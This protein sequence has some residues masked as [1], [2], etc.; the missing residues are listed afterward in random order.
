MDELILYEV[1]ERVATITLNRPEKLNAITPAL[2]RALLTALERAAE[3]ST[4]HVA[5][6]CGAGR[7]FS[8]GYDVTSGDMVAVGVPADR[9]QLEA[10]VRG[11]LA[12]WDLPLPVIA[13]VHGVCLAGGT[14]LAAICDITFVADDARIGTPQLPLGAGYVA[15]FWAWFVGPK[16][17]KEIFFPTGEIIGAAE[18][19]AMGLFNRVVPA[20]AL[21]DEVQAYARR[22]ARTPKDLLALQKLAIN[23]TQEAQGFRQALLQGAEIDAIAHAS[24]SVRAVNRFIGEHGL[25]DALGAFQRGELP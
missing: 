11:W 2:Q 12:I 8:A 4:V 13:Q 5:V 6:V 1:A 24:P 19:V 10:I 14:Q 7:G 15:S 9:A 21:A 16:K 20:G 3:D 23:R 17:A 25:R 18:T 22:V